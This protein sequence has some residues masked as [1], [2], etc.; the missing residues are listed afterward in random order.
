MKGRV[1]AAVELGLEE[2]EEEE[3][4]VSVSW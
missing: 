3:E 4:N 1:E 2:E